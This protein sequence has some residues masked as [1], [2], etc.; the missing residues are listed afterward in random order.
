ML[1]KQGASTYEQ[2]T[3]FGAERAIAG[4]SPVAGEIRTQG[5]VGEHGL[6]H[7]G[8][9]FDDA[10]CCR[11]LG[12]ALQ[13]IDEVGV[14]VHALESVGHEQTLDDADA[15]GTELRLVLVL[16]CHDSGHGNADSLCCCL[17]VLVRK[18]RIAHRHCCA[19]VTEQA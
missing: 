16:K 6:P 7:S 15:L 2:F 3:A 12:D 19:P 8:G 17:G 5:V 14:G 4:G 9:E 18:M 10:A 13:D 1:A 11:M